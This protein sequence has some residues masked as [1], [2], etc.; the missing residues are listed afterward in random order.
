MGSQLTC[1]ALPCPAAL[2]SAGGAYPQAGTPGG[3][4]PVFHADTPG[5]APS[6]GMGT[7]MHPSP[8]MVAYSPATAGT[9]AMAPTPGGA[10]PGPAS[11]Q[12]AASGAASYEHWEGVEVRLPEGEVAVVRGLPGDGTAQVALAQPSETDPETL[13]YPPD[14]PSRSVPLK[15]CALV[16][17]ER[18]DAIKVL[19]GDLAGQTG[20]LVG[21]DG[22][23]GIIKIAGDVKILSLAAIGKFVPRL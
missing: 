13:V 18:R 12:G 23:D 8:A 16:A 17:P 3:F 6:P 4:S 7:Y 14:A 22:G 1:A 15:G 21:T 5:M 9:P 20:E 19:Q 10:T 2:L 11:E